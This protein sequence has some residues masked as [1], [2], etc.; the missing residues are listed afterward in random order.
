MSGSLFGL[1]T[2][3]IV[4]V[5]YSGDAAGLALAKAATHGFVQM[6]PGLESVPLGA[7]ASDLCLVRITNTGILAISG[8]HLADILDPTKLLKWDVSAIATATTRT[9]TVPDWSGVL[10]LP[11][12]FGLS[13][14]F[15]RS[16]GAAQPTW[17]TVTLTN[18]LLDGANHVDTLAGAVAAGDVIIGNATPKWARLGVGSSGQ[19]LAVSGGLPAWTANPAV[20]HDTLLH[21]KPVRATGCAINN[22]SATLTTTGGQFANVRVGDRVNFDIAVPSIWGARVSG[23]IDS[24]NV[25]LDLTNTG[26]SQSGRTCVLTP[27]DHYNEALSEANGYALACGRGTYDASSTPGGTFQELR[28]PVNWEGYESGHST[29]FRVLGS[30]STITPW[31][32]SIRKPGTTFKYYFMVNNVTANRVLTFPDRSDEVVLLGGVQS[33]QSKTLTTGNKIVQDGTNTYSVFQSAALV[34]RLS[35]DLS[36]MSALRAVR[37]ADHVGTT[38]VE[39]A[40][41]TI[42]GVTPSVANGRTFKVTNAGATNMTGMTADH[43]AQEVNL[44]FTDGN[45]TVKDSSTTGTFELSGSADFNPAANTIMKFVRVNA[46]AKWYELS[47]SV[48]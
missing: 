20:Q 10:L 28:G 22:G 35:F 29:D 8:F 19:V 9:A 7:F 48:N 45:T 15:L 16:N 33:L 4:G 21:I 46:D 32:F 23:L 18:A 1:G 26:S 12:D 47:R 34:D 3:D 40:V 5:P 37:W 31:G 13:G 30:T 43:D 42:S 41:T 14:Q 25:T 36:A 27:G 39:A 44:L 6:G 17:S 38:A 24:N 11:T 2:G